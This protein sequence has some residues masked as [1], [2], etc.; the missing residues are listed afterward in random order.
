[1]EERLRQGLRLLAEE[2]PELGTATPR[3]RR[4]T[5]FVAAAA[6]VL[7]G[8][9]GGYAVLRPDPR[10]G[11]DA[12]CA[13][14]LRFGGMEYQ[15]WGE[16]RRLPRSG[17][18]LGPGV[19]PGCDDGNGASASVDVTV[20]AFPGVSP[21]VAVLVAGRGYAGVYVAD[22]SGPLPEAVRLTSEYVAC[23]VTGPLTLRGT[24]VSVRSPHEIE[25]DGALRLPFRIELW[26]ADPR[27]TGPEYERVT[28]VARSSEGLAVPDRSVVDRLLW[29]AQEAEATVH[30]DGD[31]F[32]LDLLRPAR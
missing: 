9:L 11:E 6:L 21:D 20:H 26:T 1:M 16:E 3:R 17:R 31:R 4:P 30:C 24:W 18:E 10:G 2:A 32:V 14:V 5:R 8:G 23:D 19:I 12:G 13:A 29:Q 27:L 7:A 25:S 22:Q 28:V 15:G